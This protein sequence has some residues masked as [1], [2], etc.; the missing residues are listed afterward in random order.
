MLIVDRY[1]AINLYS[2][3]KDCIVYYPI[4]SPSLSLLR[5]T[6]PSSHGT[7]HITLLRRS[8]WQTG[9]ERQD[10]CGVTVVTVQRN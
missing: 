9:F 7:S 10:F 3:N 4:F 5:T 8:D 6:S 1:V 2:M